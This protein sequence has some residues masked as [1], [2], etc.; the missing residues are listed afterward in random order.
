[1]TKTKWKMLK[2]LLYIVIAPVWFP[3]FIALVCVIMILSGIIAGMEELVKSIDRK[4]QNG[5]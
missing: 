5:L 4:I 2:V 1:M 3:I